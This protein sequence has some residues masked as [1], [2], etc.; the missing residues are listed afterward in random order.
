MKKLVL[1]SLEQFQKNEAALEIKQYK[2]EPQ[3]NHDRVQSHCTNIIKS[4]VSSANSLTTLMEGARILEVNTAAATQLLGAV[5]WANIP[6]RKNIG[7]LLLLKDNTEN[8]CYFFF[9]KMYELEGIWCD[10]SVEHE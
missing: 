1:V 7:D 8:I 6:F 9:E 5:Y 2:F 3:G 4:I 10:L